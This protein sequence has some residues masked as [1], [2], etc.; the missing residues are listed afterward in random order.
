MKYLEK[1]DVEIMPK[2]NVKYLCV[3]KY[4]D[5]YMKLKD[6]N[7]GKHYL[8]SYMNLNRKLDNSGWDL[9]GLD[10]EFYDNP[11]VIFYNP[12]KELNNTTL[13]ELGFI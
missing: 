5:Q 3:V 10:T 11:E 2:Q 9:D 12:L 6:K 1:D 7:G 13:I 8:Y 4:D